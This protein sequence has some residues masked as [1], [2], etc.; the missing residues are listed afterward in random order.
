MH[1]TSLI[2]IIVCIQIGTP[3]LYANEANHSLNLDGDGDYIDL[4]EV[5]RSDAYVHKLSQYTIS[6]WIKT[7][8]SNQTSWAGIVA[9]GDG[10]Y[11]WGLIASGS[12][13]YARTS[14][15][16]AINP[17]GSSAER[18]HTFNAGFGPTNQW[19]HLVLADDGTNISYYLN[20]S[21]VETQDTAVTNSGSSAMHLGRRG[22]PCPDGWG[23]SDTAAHFRGKMDEV[24]IWNVKLNTEQIESL[25]ADGNAKDAR[26]ILP[27][28][29]DHYWNF[30]NSNI[31]NIQDLGTS[32]SSR[33]TILEIKGNPIMDSSDYMEPNRKPE[34][35]DITGTGNE[36]NTISTTLIA[37]DLDS[38]D[39]N[40]FQFTIIR[41][42]NHKTGEI[43]FIDPIN[44]NPDTN[45]FSQQVTYTHNDSE[46]HSDSF[47]YQAN[48]GNLNSNISTVNLTINP[49]NDKPIITTIGNQTV[50]EGTPFTPIPLNDFTSDVDNLNNTLN[51]QYSGNTNLS[52]SIN[53]TSRIASITAIDENWNG[54]ETIT[55]TVTDTGGLTDSQE[56]ILTVEP[57]ND[58][59]II[60][61]EFNK[62]I[63]PG[64]A[65]QDIISATDADGLTDGSY[66]SITTPPNNALTFGI[67]ES[68]GEWTYTHNG[69]NNNTDS[70][71]VT[72]TDDLNFK[73]TQL[74]TI[75]IN[76]NNQ[77]PIF[78]TSAPLIATE[79]SIYNYTISLENLSNNQIPI[80]SAINLP[81]WLSLI[82]SNQQ[83]EEILLTGTPSNTHIGNHD[84][85]I[86]AQANNITVT[87]SFT[88]RVKSLTE[89]NASLA[90]NKVEIES[91]PIGITTLIITQEETND[92]RIQKTEKQ[93]EYGENG[94]I[95]KQIEKITELDLDGNRIKE[96]AIEKDSLGNPTTQTEA[97]IQADG[98]EIITQKTGDGSIALGSIEKKENTDGST[99]LKSINAIGKPIS[100]VIE[101][102][103]EDS[104]GNMVT[105]KTKKTGSGF[106]LRNTK[107]KITTGN[108]GQTIQEEDISDP[109]GISIEKITKQTRLLENGIETTTIKRN[110]QGDIIDNKIELT[111]SDG[112]LQVTNFL[113]TGEINTVSDTQ[114]LIINDK[115]FEKTTVKDQNGSELETFQTHVAANGTVTEHYVNKLKNEKQSIISNINEEGIIFKNRTSEPILNSLQT[116]QTNNQNFNINALNLNSSYTTTK[117]I[118]YQGSISLSIKA[119][120]LSND[121]DLQLSVQTLSA[122]V[123]DYE[124]FLKQLPQ[125][126]RIQNEWQLLKN[127]LE[128]VKQGELT[129]DYLPSLDNLLER[130]LKLQ[131]IQYQQN[132]GSSNLMRLSNVDNTIEI[133]EFENTQINITNH[134]L[135]IVNVIENDFYNKETNVIFNTA[136]LLTELQSGHLNS[137]LFPGDLLLTN[138]TLIPNNNTN[139]EID[140]DLNIQDAKIIISLNAA[141]KATAIQLNDSSEIIVQDPDNI[142][143]NLTLPLNY[144]LLDAEM[145]SGEFKTITVPEGY[146]S[147]T[148]QLYSEGI[149]IIEKNTAITESEKNKITDFYIYPSPIIQGDSFYIGFYTKN[150]SRELTLHIFDIFGQL[151]LE[152]KIYFHINNNS[153]FDALSRISG[154][155]Y[156][157]QP[158]DSREFHYP[159][160]GIYIATIS[161]DNKVLAKTKVGVIPR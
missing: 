158:I 112:S 107:I 23:C 10:N 74:I 132:N 115:V 73:T 31:N 56:V 18:G 67:N 42:P 89:I 133:S 54:S 46:N 65:I 38:S 9:G 55:F 26:D 37:T 156:Y 145:I 13:I 72:I 143:A 71:I 104:S 157:Y 151:H 43:T 17:G 70:F 128:L 21:L 22:D 75:N 83:D 100:I 160:A 92:N 127:Q 81:N 161:E 124:A 154:E 20:G 98:T 93:I 45:T 113:P 152:K 95:L 153:S 134:Y 60:S 69:N 120:S 64:E 119:Q 159:S 35:F 110:S 6:V 77:I 103:Q 139:I 84:I 58:A 30:N 53:D 91:S 86:I 102:Q 39:I 123:K 15:G 82:D 33:W 62:T 118:N 2:L 137:S 125:S 66:Y 52:V 59:T 136:S 7:D 5:G 108:N 105:L 130:F 19:N 76:T 63:Q 117:E 146:I 34:T 90:G 68:S 135:D 140:G 11:G 36:G 41:P 111:K 126:I 14:T 29:L 40:Q 51:W 44:Y 28:N 144:T 116:I 85:K 106:E 114:T 149:L 155:N 48:D 94:R 88:I 32:T 150:N 138:G 141:I 1:I 147:N 129:L 16:D 78:K 122:T 50:T 142:L 101:K 49:I 80:F 109:L 96:I 24:A 61:G 8:T 79:N 47:T 87:Q 99:T 97:T 131:E 25:Y 27:D 12:K 57:E 4:R 121:N 148:S 3:S